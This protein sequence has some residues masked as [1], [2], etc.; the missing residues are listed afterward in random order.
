[1]TVLHRRP[2]WW[3]IGGTSLACVVVTLATVPFLVPVDRYRALLEEYIRGATGRDVQIAALRLEVWPRPQVRARD[4]RLMNPPGF[5][6]GATIDAQTADLGVDLRA[7]LNRRLA[8]NRITLS[9]VHVNFLTS[10]TGR[11]NFDL[12][13]GSGSPPAPSTGGTSGGQPL[14]TLNP[15]GVVG[16]KKVDLSVGAYDPRRRYV[17]PSFAITGLNAGSRSVDV[18]APDWLRRLEVTVDLTGARLA[19]PSL[20]APVQVQSGTLVLKG[21][22]AKATFAVALDTMRATGTA[23]IARLDAPAISFAL[24]IPELDVNRLQRLLRARP[25][26]G[27]SE[28]SGPIGPRRLV[29]GGTVGIDKFAFAPLAAAGLR[30]QLGIYTDIVRVGAYS[31]N[32]YGGTVTG[33]AALDP[34][35]AGTPVTATVHARRVDLAGLV[36]AV[37]PRT[38]QLSGALDADLALRTALAGDPR[39]ALTGAGTFAI[40]D[41]SFPGLDVKSAL[42]QLA[43]LLRTSVR[44]GRTR[45]GYFGGD[46]RIA[47]ERAYSS[48]LRLD[49]ENLNATGRGSAGFDGTLDYKGTGMMGQDGSAPSPAAGPLPSAAGVL[50]G[51]VP[52]AAG[53]RAARVPFTLSGALPNPH[54]AL[55]GVP[56]LVDWTGA[57]PAPPRATPAS[58]QVP[59]FPTFWQT[60]PNLP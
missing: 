11:S 29:A 58:P 52:G 23:A 5:P 45:F 4:V 2:R 49:G 50:G 8:I 18:A 17:T 36:R 35:A 38:Q 27:A 53:G 1:V 20:R 16:I 33:I 47:R 42:A 55:A 48:A 56:Q 39:A 22:G 7:L 41:G 43:R 3:V 34:A 13:A 44:A 12:P 51:Y 28:P 32:A 46:V 21:G 60:L 25:A 9:G 6:P 57:S 37:A 31:L 19:V 10:T 30:A 24:A 54:F 40:R 26:P 14:L 59:G 15:I